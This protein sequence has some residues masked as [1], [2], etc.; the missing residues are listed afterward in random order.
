MSHLLSSIV[1]KLSK[2]HISKNSFL[3]ALL[4]GVLSVTKYMRR[5]FRETVLPECF[6]RRSFHL[7]IFVVSNNMLTRCCT[8]VRKTVLMIKQ[9]HTA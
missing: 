4:Y 1:V 9:S 6:Q 8:E 3:L 2:A 7:V 5:R